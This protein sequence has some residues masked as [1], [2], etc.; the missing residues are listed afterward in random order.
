MKKIYTLIIA[1]TLITGFTIGSY[2]LPS[3]KPFGNNTEFLDSSGYV[4]L[5]K[6]F[7]IKDSLF[8]EK[9][10]Y[11][12][13]ALYLDTNRNGKIFYSG[14]AGNELTIGNYKSGGIIS[15]PLPLIVSGTSSYIGFPHLTSTERDAIISSGID[16][17]GFVL[18][19]TTD[20]KLQVHVGSGTF[21][22]LH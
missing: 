16:L 8:V 11:I 21:N 3:F 10:G 7:K 9:D 22:N 14:A 2:Y 17:E 5:N 18:W 12:A 1:F 6:G 4:R 13:G 19:N 20:G 15:I